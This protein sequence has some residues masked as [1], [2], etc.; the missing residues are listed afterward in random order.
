MGQF[1]IAVEQF[2]AMKNLAVF[3]WTHGLSAHNLMLTF[4]AETGLV[5]TIAFLML[6]VSIVLFAWK[7]VRKGQSR[8]SLSF[9]WGLFMIFTVLAI[10]VFFAGIWYYDFAFFLALLVLYTRKLESSLEIRDER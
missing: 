10:W 4:L 6:L 2:P 7:G 9:G 8:E 1:A 5:G 3:E